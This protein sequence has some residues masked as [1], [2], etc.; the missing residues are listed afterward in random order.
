MGDKGKE[1][2]GL[3]SG[4]TNIIGNVEDVQAPQT[5]HA[6]SFASLNMGP[7][8]EPMSGQ[9]ASNEFKDISGSLKYSKRTGSKSR[10]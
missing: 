4:G 5:D 8:D 1:K 2:P 6:L 10:K 9:A 7:K 3:I